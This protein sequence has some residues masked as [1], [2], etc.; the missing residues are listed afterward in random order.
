MIA[1][2]SRQ[3]PIGGLIDKV[4]S[5]NP[6]KDA[7]EDELA[8]IDLSAVDN[9]AKAVTG[10]QTVLGRDAPSRARQ[11]VRSGD[12]LVST[13]RPNLNG[14]ARVPKELDGATA[15]TGFC[16][17]R[18]NPSKLDG[19]Y[20]FHWVRSPAFVADMVR[21][22]TGASY[23]AVSD[24]I[25]GQS[26]IPLPPLAEQKR[27]AAILDQADELRRKRQRALDRLNQLG[28]AIFIEM[29]GDPKSNPKGWTS[30]RLGD[31]CDVG[32]SKRVFVEEFVESGVPFYRGT[33]VGKLGTGEVISPSLFIA[34]EHYDNLIRHSGK[35]EIGDLLLPSICHDGRIWRVDSSK[36]FYFKDGRV[37]WIKS[38]RAQL[39]SEYLR[40]YLQ[41]RFRYDYPSIASGTTFAELKIINLKSLMV[42]S[43]PIELQAAFS[44]RISAI[45]ALRP[46]YS[47][48]YLRANALFA[49]LQTRAFRG[50]LTTSSL[51][52][53]AA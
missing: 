27:I 1:E 23:P 39:D 34:P 7:P 14:V 46:P 43:P 48:A 31:L 24:K 4:A 41:N 52:E 18:P 15:S 44:R 9:T 28:Q 45:E 30:A 49:S 5:W 37:L 20:L 10:L 29:F 53:A 22:A 3:T 12:I 40:R 51:R 47:R 17:L 50:E 11:L 13:V 21:K 16:V 33:E 38:H 32:S 8:Y 2:Q 36:P 35:P 6:A 25:I 19:N 42:L 26:E